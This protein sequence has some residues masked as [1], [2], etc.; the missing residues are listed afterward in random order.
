M[1]Q[2]VSAAERLGLDPT[3]LTHADFD[4]ILSGWF[5]S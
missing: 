2:G 4:Q 3:G 1:D 5:A